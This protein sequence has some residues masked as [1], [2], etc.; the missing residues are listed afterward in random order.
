MEIP[1]RENTRNY[2]VY[3]RYLNDRKKAKLNLEDKHKAMLYGRRFDELLLEFN[4]FKAII[5]KKVYRVPLLRFNVHFKIYSNKRRPKLLLNRIGTLMDLLY[6]SG[7]AENCTDLIIPCISIDSSE[8]D[9]NNPRVEVTLS[10]YEPSDKGYN[11]DENM[12]DFKKMRRKKNTELSSFYFA[13]K[14]AL[15]L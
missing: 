11:K 8:F 6:Y 1:A 12:E 2:G 7:I 15:K 4:K 5:E 14:R 9:F 10:V 3:L 13:K